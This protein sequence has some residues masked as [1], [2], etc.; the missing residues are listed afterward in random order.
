M[1][2]WF[3]HLCYHAIT[4]IFIVEHC[5][6][7]LCSLEYLSTSHYYLS[8]VLFGI[9]AQW[10]SFLFG[11][12]LHKFSLLL[13]AWPLISLKIFERTL[14]RL[15]GLDSSLQVGLLLPP[16]F[17]DTTQRNSRVITPTDPQIPIFH[18]DILSEEN[19][20]VISATVPID[21]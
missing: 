6:P 18:Q 9:H 13:N 2:C 3:L 16:G 4:D 19:L 21:I 20:G 5:L 11:Q 12:K 10:I 15:E 17:F 7:C 8:F 14:S 1:G